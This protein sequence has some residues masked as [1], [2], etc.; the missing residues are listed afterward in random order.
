MISQLEWY[1]DRCALPPRILS[2]ALLLPSSLVS[3][4]KDPQVQSVPSRTTT[5]AFRVA[6]V[7]F[8]IAPALIA[9]QNSFGDFVVG[10][11]DSG[12]CIG[13]YCCDGSLIGSS[14]NSNDASDFTCCLGDSN[15]G[16][17]NGVP[18]A[19]CTAGSAVPLTATTGSVASTSAIMTSVASSSAQPTSADSSNVSS[20]DSSDSS[21]SSTSTE[22][23]GTS[24]LSG[25][26]GS[27]TTSQRSSIISTSTS[28]PSSSNSASTSSESASA[29]ATGNAAVGGY[30]VSA[31]QVAVGILALGYSIAL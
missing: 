27:S 10:S 6:T 20:D 13:N 31:G 28:T 22:A 30:Q 29:G 8:S 7:L 26:M 23:A 15:H 2:S 5:M 1:I 25:S 16:I 14:G 12:A 17:V 19:T 21:D 9:G 18:D 3:S 11:N 4:T 24:T